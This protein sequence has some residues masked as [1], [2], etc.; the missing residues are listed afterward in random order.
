MEIVQ[1]E[2]ERGTSQVKI[3]PSTSKFYPE[4]FCFPEKIDTQTTKSVPLNLLIAVPSCKIEN[5]LR[6]GCTVSP[7]FR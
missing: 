3:V 4:W 1:E 2:E 5:A 6:G 7:A